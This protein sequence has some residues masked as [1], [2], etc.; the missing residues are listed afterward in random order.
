MENKFPDEE[1]ARLADELTGALI[2]LARVIDN[3]PQSANEGTWRVLIQGLAA[4]AENSGADKGALAEEIR[5]AREEKNRLAPNCAACLA[6]CGR[7]D[8]Y[9]MALLA[10][11][12]DDVLALKTRILSGARKLAAAAYADMLAGAAAENAGGLIAHALFA[13]GEDWEAGWLLPVA[14]ETESKTA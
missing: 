8:D 1:T 13:V 10:N 5:L 3:D 14:E 2:G 9:D 11:A 6:R 4:T 12:E 7:S